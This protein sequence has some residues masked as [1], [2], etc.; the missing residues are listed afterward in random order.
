MDQYHGHHQ[1]M[2]EGPVMFILS[3][4]LFFLKI[5]EPY[6]QIMADRGFK[7][8]TTLAFHQCTL[9]IPPSGAKGV[10]FTSAQ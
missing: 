7:I 9:A 8:K 6:D 5:L 3:K 4:F 10:Q 2:V 1:H